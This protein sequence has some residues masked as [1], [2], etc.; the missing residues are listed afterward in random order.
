MSS[1]N[2][3]LLMMLLGGGT[4]GRSQEWGLLNGSST[5]IRGTQR[6]PW[7]SF[8]RMRNKEQLVVGSLEED[9]S[10]CWH[11]ILD[12]QPWGIWEMSLCYCWP[13]QLLV[14]S[15]SS[16]KGPRHLT[17]CTYHKLSCSGPSFRRRKHTCSSSW[18]PLPFQ[19]NSVVIFFSPIIL[20]DELH[21]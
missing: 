9:S 19:R 1:P 12:R 20:I 18:I 7:L 21:E 5:I 17:T 11:L 16:W 4:F 13:T 2:S 3:W 15:Y 8:S 14:L 6:A 10:P